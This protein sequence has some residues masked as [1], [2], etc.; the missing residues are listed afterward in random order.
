MSN[1]HGMLMNSFQTEPLQHIK[2]LC[3]KL[4]DLPNNLFLNVC[5]ARSINSFN[6]SEHNTYK[7]IGNGDLPLAYCNGVIGKRNLFAAKLLLEQYEKWMLFYLKTEDEEGLGEMVEK[8]LKKAEDFNKGYKNLVAQDV[9]SDSQSEDDDENEY[10]MSEED[11][12]EDIFDVSSQESEE[13]FEFK[14]KKKEVHEKKL[15]KFHFR[16]ADSNEKEVIEESSDE[17]K[18]DENYFEISGLAEQEGEGEKKQRKRFL[19]IDDAEDDLFEIGTQ[20]VP[21]IAS[22]KKINKTKQRNQQIKTRFAFL[23]SAT[24]MT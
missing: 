24:L 16:E 13:E 6:S 21:K 19:K 23:K 9:Y 15:R 11:D 1:Y 10:S 14:S 20:N 3:F 18:N 22:S 8:D 7:V 5:T 12:D 2:T 17:T 4:P